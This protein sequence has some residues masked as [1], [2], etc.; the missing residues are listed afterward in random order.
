MEHSGERR[1][2]GVCDGTSVSNLL[3]DLALYAQW[4]ANTYTVTFDGN[5][6]TSGA[7]SATNVT[8]GADPVALTLNNFEK[9]GYSFVGWNTQADGEGTAYADGQEVSNLTSSF[10]LY[11]QWTANT[12]EVVFVGN[13]STSGTT[14]S[15][16]VTYG[17][18]AKALTLNGF[19][20]I[21]Y[22]FSGWNTQADGEGAVF[23]DG[24]LVSDLTESI[25]LYAQWTA[26]TYTVT[27]DGNG[28]TSGTMD[29]VSVTYG[30][31]AVTLT[32][33]S[34]SK[35]GYTFSGWNTQADGE[36]TA[37]SDGDSVSDLTSAITL[38]AQWTII[39]YTISYDGNG[40]DGGSTDA[41]N[42]EYGGTL[43]VSLNGFTRTGYS[44]A[45][46]NTQADG[47]GTSYAAGD[48][49][50]DM[51]SILTLYAQW[52]ADTYAVTF[53]GNGSTSGS[54]PSVSVTYGAGEVT[55]PANG[56]T[57]T[58]YTF[59]G[60]NT[61]ANGGGVSY[62]DGSSVSDLLSDL[63]LYAQ[64]TADTY[65][66]SFDGNGSTSGTTASMQVTYGEAAKALTAN[67][68]TRDD[69]SFAGWNTAADGSGTSYADGAEISDLTA[70]L[71]LYA[72]WEK[73]DGAGAG[74]ALLALATAILIV[75][76]VAGAVAAVHYNVIRP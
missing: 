25:I 31:G 66:V 58:G 39:T 37:Y 8:Y 30:A 16:Q 38:Y 3:S 49:I 45:G 71:V 75:L 24:A 36:G 41:Q 68:F 62:A 11:A 48:E 34:F 19:S 9:I 57:K 60:W 10:T 6:S 29:P 28:S 74:I 22:S 63:T 26:N 27:F 17:E 73:D 21:G 70:D 15:M 69:Y 4:S 23:V 51:T 7:T 13:G 53:D 76:F 33:N 40:A 64:W 72:Q 20:R 32:S 18:A 5:G 35:T 59:T 12:Y 2:D 47:E 55:L 50:A 46:W 42:V 54:I 65:T 1:R 52:T 61:Q 44:F 67:G 43:A 56:F 14:A